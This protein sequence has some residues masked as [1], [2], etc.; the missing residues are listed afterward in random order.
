MKRLG[1]AVA[2]GLGI[3]GVGAF[4]VAEQTPR[5]VGG[6]GIRPVGPS[7]VPT[8][9]VFS[10]DAF[11]L[12][13]DQPQAEP[14]SKSTRSG[15]ERSVDTSAP[16]VN[17]QNIRDIEAK[18]GSL[19]DDHP[20]YSKCFKEERARILNQVDQQQIIREEQQSKPLKNVPNLRLAPDED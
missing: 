11:K 9:Q 17:E 6:P 8:L 20:E 18:C 2:V 12:S 13:V 5:P 15:A 7:Q 14:V 3:A 10:E 4:L 19:K 1:M 16:Q